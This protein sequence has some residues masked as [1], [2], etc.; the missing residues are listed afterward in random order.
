MNHPDSEYATKYKSATLKL[1]DG[2]LLQGKI[3][4][5]PHERISDFINSR[6]KTFVVVVEGSS[7]EILPKTIFVNKSKVAW[8]EP[9]I[10]L[11]L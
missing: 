2:T 6:D 3:N 10:V 7:H 5:S 9:E 1:V 4:I 11:D 8:I